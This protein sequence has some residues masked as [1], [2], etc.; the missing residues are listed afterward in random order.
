[1]EQVKGMQRDQ[2][3]GAV[4]VQP[5]ACPARSPSGSPPRNRITDRLLA[6]ARS[7]EALVPFRGSSGLAI[8]AGTASRKRCAKFGISERRVLHRTYAVCSAAHL[9][10]ASA[11]TWR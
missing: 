10:V 4:V 7:S 1:M 3:G 9:T 6:A 11:C 8:T 2:P 5:R